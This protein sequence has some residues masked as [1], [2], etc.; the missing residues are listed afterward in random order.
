MN[1]DTSLERIAR[2]NDYL[3][4]VAGEGLRTIPGHYVENPL[5]VDLDDWP[6][7]GGRGVIASVNPDEDT[8]DGHIIEIPSSGSLAPERH[9]Y[10]ELIHVIAGRGTTR[11]WNGKGTETSFEW[12]KGSVFSV[13]LNTYSQHFNTSGREPARFYSVTTAP[14]MMR[15][16]HNL[17]FIY[18]CDYDFTDRFGQDQSDFSGE[19]TAYL[20]PR[21]AGRPDLPRQNR[22]WETNFIASVSDFQL[23]AWKER[24]AGGSN[25]LFELANSS[26]CGHISEFP[27][28]TYK[29]AHRHGPGA[30]VSIVSGTGFSLMWRDDQPIRRYDWTAGSVIVPGDRWFHQH[31]NT[32][33]TPARYLALRWSSQKYP[34]FRQFAVSKP[35]TEGGDQIEY[36]DEDPKVREMFEADL[37]K[38][39]MSSRMS[40]EHLEAGGR[41]DV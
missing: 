14:L 26:M 6:R 10:E 41:H 13:P 17:D 30:H 2:R 24:G 27:V 38:A 9:M 8:N 40:Y 28:G 12:R 37:A 35:T 3:N 23:T 1:D 7:R 31:F 22:V 4:W 11:I 18:N 15:L 21:V 19:G 25:I 32:G 29:K 36:R 33:D 16:I 5:T 34:V 20:V 39:G